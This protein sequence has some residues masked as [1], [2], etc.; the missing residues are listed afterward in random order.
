MQGLLIT[1]GVI[2][3]IVVFAFGLAWLA[4]TRGGKRYKAVQKL[5]DQL[6]QVRGQARQTTAQIASSEVVSR[7]VIVDSKGWGQYRTVKLELEVKDER[8]QLAGSGYWDVQLTAMAHVAPGKA[9][10]IAVHPT[11]R[12]ILYPAETWA[13][14]NVDLLERSE[15]SVSIT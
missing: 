15:P 4:L 7:D 11:Q 1:L 10:A 12:E 5:A 6:E 14:L 9:V 13:R 3:G 8:G 2:A